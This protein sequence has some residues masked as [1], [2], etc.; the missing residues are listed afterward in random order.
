MP[1]EDGAASHARRA[2]SFTIWFSNPRLTPSR[3]PTSLSRVVLPDRDGP[4]MKRE[5]GDTLPPIT[6]AG[7]SRSRARFARCRAAGLGIVGPDRER[8]LALRRRNAAAVS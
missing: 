8:L 1:V 7:L 3:V 2:A 4:R 6:V 5:M